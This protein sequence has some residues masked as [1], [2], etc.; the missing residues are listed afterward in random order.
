MQRPCCGHA[1]AAA[2]GSG[3]TGYLCMRRFASA[4]RRSSG[5]SSNQVVRDAKQCPDDGGAL[6]TKHVGPTRCL[7]KDRQPDLMPALRQACGAPRPRRRTTAVGSLPPRMVLQNMPVQGLDSHRPFRRPRRG[8]PGQ[9]RRG[10]PNTAKAA[11]RQPGLSHT[12]LR[13]SLACP[14]AR[15]R[16]EG[17]PPAAHCRAPGARLRPCRDIGQDPGRAG[18]RLRPCQMRRTRR[19][20]WE[21]C[22]D[23]RPEADGVMDLCLDQSLRMSRS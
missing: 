9:C 14:V 18:G 2:G 20:A 19:A 21:I 13:Q 17:L 15:S 3:K 23:R 22:T 6:Q 7:H 11:V 4:M 12:A 1:A 10:D 8:G 5:R 16:A